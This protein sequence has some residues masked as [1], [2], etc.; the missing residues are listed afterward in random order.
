MICTINWVLFQAIKEIVTLHYADMTKVSNP[1]NLGHEMH[2]DLITSQCDLLNR[3]ICRL[4]L[5]LCHLSVGVFFHSFT[6]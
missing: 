2:F 3:C 6:K 1:V 4:S 5:H